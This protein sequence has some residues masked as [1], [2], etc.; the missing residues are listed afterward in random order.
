M[1]NQSIYNRIKS[2]LLPDGTLPEDFVL[3]QQPEQGM[4]FADG[5]GNGFQGGGS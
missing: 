3:R 4:R 2:A 1:E 5:A